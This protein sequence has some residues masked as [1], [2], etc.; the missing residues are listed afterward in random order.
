VRCDAIRLVEVFQNLLDNAVRF[1]QGQPNSV[2]RVGCRTDGDRRVVFVRDNG[3]GIEPQYLQRIFNLFEQLD[4]RMGGTGL[5]LAITKRI[6]EVHG[7][8]IWAESEGLG[9]G[10][11]FCFTLPEAVGAELSGG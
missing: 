5:G 8:A 6:I 7:G 11:T 9:K 4:P 3:V 2:V 1:S 10:A